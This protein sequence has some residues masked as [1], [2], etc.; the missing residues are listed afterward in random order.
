MRP[1]K[2][3]RQAIAYGVSL[4][5]TIVLVA[6]FLPFREN[7][8]P[9]TKAFGFL[10]VVVAAAGIGGIWPGIFAS[11]L[12]FLVFNF[13][14]LPPYDT[15]VIGKAEYVV[16][17]FVNLGISVLISLLIGR[18]SDRAA[19]AEAREA[20]L[21][22]LQ[23]LSRELVVRG[24]GRDAYREIIA[25]VLSMFGYRAGAL[26]VRDA[27]QVGGLREEV[28]VGC[29]SG[30]IV[31]EW[32]PRSPERP[33]E[34]LPLSVGSNNVGLLVLTGSRDAPSE[35]ESRILRAFGDQLALVLERDRLLRTATD[36]EV[37][38]QTER[39]RQTLL[40]AVSH[41]LRSPL[42]AIKASVTDLL[43]DDV[44]RSPAE[45]RDALEAIDSESERLN[46]LIANLLDMS[47]IEAGVL[48]ARVETVDV[49]DVISTSVDNVSN[50]WPDLRVRERLEEG[51]M[52]RADPVFLDR[53]LT[54]LLDNAARSANGTVSD[55]E[56]TTRRNEGL[57]TIRVIDHGKGISPE[58]RELLFHPFYELDQRNPR[59]GSGLGLAIAKGF[60]SAMG[61]EIWVEDTPGGGA[62]FAVSV[63]AARDAA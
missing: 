58:G 33:P 50:V 47:R 21:R 17:L 1:P 25:S 11:V 4:V 60:V 9:L 23:E 51:V 39:L 49:G 31:P 30:E 36:A 29:E 20:E 43:E 14:F 18:A 35:A 56:V 8:E 24:P 42:A 15:F 37:Y 63:P 32:D 38:R 7:V 26:F 13:Y 5:G 44:E 27:A 41:D 6:A 62:T 57:V 48:H 55:V 2:P 61:G 52:A 10:L 59:L 12:A 46:A 28:A 53:V 16:V 3:R 54:N 22:T 40:A 34:R 19:A 45:R